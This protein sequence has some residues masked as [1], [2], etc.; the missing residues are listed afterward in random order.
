M[1]FVLFYKKNF[2]VDKIH[3]LVH[4]SRLLSVILPLDSDSRTQ[5]SHDSG[6]REFTLYPPASSDSD[7]QEEGHTSGAGQET[8]SGVK[9]HWSVWKCKSNITLTD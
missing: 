6:Y 2:I 5:F 8:H 3:T 9:G 7:R 4:L 1:L